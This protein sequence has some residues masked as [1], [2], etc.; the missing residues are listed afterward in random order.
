MS[1]SPELAP[2]GAGVPLAP[3]I[4]PPALAPTARQERLVNVDFARG[5]A[6]LG[7]LLVNVSVMFG[8]GAALMDP[9][10]IDRLSAGDRT[11]SLLVKSVCQAKF[12][13]IFSMLFGYGLY[14]QIQKAA[15]SGRSPV[16]FT[17]RRLGVLALF[18]L[19]H[20]LLIWY[21]D[22]LFLYACLGAWLLL[23]RRSSPRVLAGVGIGLLTLGL[24]L[25]AGLMWL[26]TRVERGAPPPS[27]AA[28]ERAPEAVRAM[29]RAGFDPASPAWIEAETAAYA[30]GPWVDAQVFRTV[31]WLISQVVSLLVFGWTVLGMFF[32]GAALWRLRFFAPEQRELRWRVFRVCLPPGLAFE[33]A[34]AYFFWSRPLSDAGTLAGEI[35]HQAGLFF[36]PLGYLSG[37]ALL[38]DRLP[39]VL[40]G[41]VASA[42]RM[43]LT[44]Y[45]SESVIATALAYH[46]G[47]GLFGRVG[48]LQQVGVAVAV[49]AALVTLSHLWQ[50]R[51]GT[52]PMEWLW[53]RL[54]YG[55]A[56]R[57]GPLLQAAP[58]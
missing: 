3:R 50:T 14:N 36:L 45:L 56:A 49:W 2:A 5:V 55:R 10:Y 28:P 32:F 47:L 40:R 53:R 1:I 31:E 18:G 21:G 16:W 19:A 43:S 23:A 37:L 29:F 15:A 54:E 52:G 33:A 58:R 39:D 51:V 38:A 42:G 4:D 12:I 41:P 13:S 20:G 26:T 24:L 7:I 44:V 35:I 11:A 30:R 17:F 57:G 46:W 9:T 48:P 25:G 22:V 8:P 6:L 27:R 34:A